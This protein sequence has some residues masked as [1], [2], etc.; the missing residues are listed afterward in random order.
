MFKKRNYREFKNSRKYLALT[1][2]TLS[3]IEKVLKL[4]LYLIVEE[5][6]NKLPPEI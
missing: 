1:I 3:D 2:I 5:I 4:K 6:K